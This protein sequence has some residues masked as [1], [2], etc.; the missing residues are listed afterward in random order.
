MTIETALGELSSSGCDVFMKLA[1]VAEWFLRDRP[2]L[3]VVE[4]G[5]T[6]ERPGI[7]GRKGNTVL[8]DAISQAQS[9]LTRD[10]TLPALARQ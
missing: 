2:R 1:P 9:V 4:T 3:K 7:C 5:I 10:G 8:R 6:R